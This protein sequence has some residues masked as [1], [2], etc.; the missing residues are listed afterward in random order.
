MT[1]KSG[2]AGSI[3]SPAAPVQAEEAAS[4]NPGETTRAAADTVTP[5]RPPQGSTKAPGGQGGGPGGGG[6]SPK[7]S[8]IEIELLDSGGKP[9]AGEEYLCELPD[10]T[11]DTGTLDNEGLVR[12]EGIVPGT[13]RVSFPK[14]DGSSWK[15]A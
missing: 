1:P 10:G 15:K 3:V 9:V 7:T 14:L 11:V 5:H 4:A 13:C 12:I 6:N 2:T 8:W